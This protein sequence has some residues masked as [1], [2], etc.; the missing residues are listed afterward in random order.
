M[1]QLAALRAAVGRGEHPRLVR[2][3]LV[4]ATRAAAEI[5]EWFGGDLARALAIVPRASGGEAASPLG[6]GGGANARVVTRRFD[7]AAA[8]HGDCVF[9]VR[10]FATR[11]PAGAGGT[12]GA[13][14][15][16]EFTTGRPD[17]MLEVRFLL[18]KCNLSKMDTMRFNR[19]G[20]TISPRNSTPRVGEGVPRRS[21]A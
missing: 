7:G 3:T 20:S 5:D 6:R 16:L 1:P 12:L 19:E 11:E 2:V 15:P 10:L 8:A 21:E 4:W 18:G 17:V 14:A 13:G 9:N